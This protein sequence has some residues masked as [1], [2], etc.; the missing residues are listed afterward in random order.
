MMAT[1]GDPR[2]PHRFWE[3]VSPEPNTGC[4]LW[5]GSGTQ[6]GYG[7]DNGGLR[8]SRLAHRITYGALVGAIPADHQVDHLCRTPACCNPDHLEAVTRLENVRRG[9]GGMAG[10]MVRGAMQTAKTHCPVG[11][12]YDARNT[13][14]YVDRLGR[15]GRYCR[16]CHTASNARRRSR[17]VA[18]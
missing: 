3:K 13:R 15:T 14:V 16:A 11:H 18:R 1:F 7:Q 4:W 5:M 8:K 12:E 6:N 10:G 2:L 9:A 17:R